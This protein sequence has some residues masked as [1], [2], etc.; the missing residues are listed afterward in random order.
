MYKVLVFKCFYM[1]NKYIIRDCLIQVI[2][3]IQKL[4]I[5]GLKIAFD[6]V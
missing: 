3:N 4:K 5:D 1:C 2:Y 6:F